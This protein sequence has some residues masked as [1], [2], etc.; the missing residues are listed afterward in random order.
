M[1]QVDL[2]TVG[3]LEWCKLEVGLSWELEVVRY[4]LAGSELTIGKLIGLLLFL[5]DARLS[6]VLYWDQPV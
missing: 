1:G 5:T 2:S 6:E 3:L 4:E